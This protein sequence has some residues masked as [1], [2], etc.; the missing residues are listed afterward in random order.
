VPAL[1]RRL[2]VLASTLALAPALW[3][4]EAVPLPSDAL[5]CLT[6]SVEHRG[7]PAYPPA[8]LERNENG[9][10]DVELNFTRADAAPE[11]KVLASR[12]A[13]DFVEAVRAYVAANRVPCLQPGRSATLR[14]AFDF[15]LEG[16]RNVLASRPRDG[17][18]ARTSRM[19]GCSTKP[20]PPQYPMGSAFRGESGTVVLKLRF[21]PARDEA[22]VSV[23]D[24]ADARWLADE[25][26]EHARAIRV[27]CLDGEPVEWLIYYMFQFQDV[28]P[29]SFKDMQ[30]RDLVASSKNLDTAQV[31]FD[32]RS[33]GCPFDLRIWF[34]QPHAA[35]RVTEVGTSDPERYFFLDW[36][37]R[38]QLNLPP[39]VHNALIGQP[40]K[41]HVPCTVVHLG[42]RTGGGA[43]Q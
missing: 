33:M 7:R 43:A 17:S 14:Q 22:R 40:A 30:L 32:T 16:G 9:R 41:V 27:P 4:Q 1:S 25:A 36:L 8:P 3:A 34:E 15:K 12:G 35:N 42:T 28:K 39:R 23:L 38:L 6:P 11:V 5:Q 37:S 24:D 21:E 20:P 18:T 29:A 19:I 10:V 26:L 13:A 2:L 31:Y